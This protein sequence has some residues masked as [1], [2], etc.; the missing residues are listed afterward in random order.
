MAWTT[1]SSSEPQSPC[2]CW[3]RGRGSAASVLGPRED[4]RGGP[5]RGELPEGQDSGG[6]AAVFGFTT[7]LALVVTMRSKATE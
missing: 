6:L 4:C 1:L 3:G 2:L 5:G 7:D